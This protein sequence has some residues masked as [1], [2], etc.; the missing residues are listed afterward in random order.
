MRKKIL[1]TGIAGFIG[2]ALA[3]QLIN[4]GIEVVGIDNLSGDNEEMKRLRLADLGIGDAD[5]A[6]EH[7]MLSADVSLLRFMS[8]D[9]ADASCM[10]KLFADEQFSCVV[11][12][13]GQAGV[14]RSAKDP[15]IYERS[16]LAGFLNVLEGC[17][18]SDPAPLL[19][20]ASS[21][22]VYG[23]RT[24]T[25]F[26]ESDNTDCPASFYA[27]TKKAN[28]L[29]AFS[30][31]S[32]FGLH[33]VALRFFS[34]YGPWGRPDMAPYIFLKA[35]KEGKPIP[36]F[37]DGTAK[38][39]FTFI[40][41]VIACISRI[42]SQPPV[43]LF[44]VYNIGCSSPATT[45]DLISAIEQAVGKKADVATLPAQLGDVPATMA[46]MMRFTDDYG[47]SP[48]TTLSQ[49]IEAFCRWYNEFYKC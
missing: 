46:D 34:V 32:L 10:A 30:Y 47:F 18:H 13:A 1:I 39:D 20:F 25:P 6:V 12:L 49:G 7:P 4:Q 28:E 15:Y 19:L 29:M 41:D 35:V 43:E 45:R 23:K 11:N 14:R 27:A 33:A 9:L 8:L 24:K 5:A 40:D 42:M 44:K 3:K 16:N 26:S 22:S 37:G 38:R 2:H 48:H 36:L 17:R 21:S 31:S